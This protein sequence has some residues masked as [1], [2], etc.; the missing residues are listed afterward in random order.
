MFKLLGAMTAMASLIP[1][2]GD[3]RTETP[4][5]LVAEPA[6]GGVRVQVLGKSKASYAASFALQVEAGGNVSRHL[7][8]ATLLGGEVVT[9]STVTVGLAP[10][11]QWRASL[12]V[13]PKSGNPYEQVRTSD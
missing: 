8:S 7:G 5:Y 3:D 6:E 4:I 2:T 1:G 9:L 10:A 11:A 12:R 13:E